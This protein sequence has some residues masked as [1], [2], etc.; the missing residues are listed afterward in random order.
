MAR[1]RGQGSGVRGQNA[2]KKSEYPTEEQGMSNVQVGARAKRI[3][4]TAV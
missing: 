4:I 3:R 1:G 2:E